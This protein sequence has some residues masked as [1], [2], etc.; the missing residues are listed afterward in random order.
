MYWE[1]FWWNRN[2]VLFVIF[3]PNFQEEIPGCGHRPCTCIGFQSWFHFPIFLVAVKMAPLKQSSKLSRGKE[4]LADA[5]EDNQTR[6]RQEEHTNKF[7]E[8]SAEKCGMRKDSSSYN[9]STLRPFPICTPV[10]GSCTE[11][12]VAVKTTRNPKLIHWPVENMLMVNLGTC[13]IPLTVKWGSDTWSIV[14]RGM[15]D[16]LAVNTSL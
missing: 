14:A 9:P 7:G 15:A 16:L 4:L 2:L 13:R 11:H 10:R 6:L 3:P 8:P 5:G 12:D 1:P